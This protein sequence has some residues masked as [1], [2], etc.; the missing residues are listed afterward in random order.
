MTK[1]TYRNWSYKLFPGFYES[2]LYNSDS[3]YYAN[4]F[5]SEDNIRYELKN[6]DG[7]INDVAK[8]ITERVYEPLFIKDDQIIKS[9]KY[10]GLHSPRYYNFETDKILLD[11]EIDQPKLEKY[12]FITNKKD[13]DKYL[14]ENF[15]SYDG[16]N[17]FIENNL[18]NFIIQYEDE[19]KENRCLDLL[20]EFYILS[21]LTEDEIE[22]LQDDMQE[23]ANDVLFEYMERVE[24]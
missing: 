8:K 4:E 19:G 7:F 14:H 1:C 24:E 23:I 15:T 16:F 9:I 18:K 2:N 22:N 12:C 13:F 3:E 17:S 10:N 20:I 6:F 11:L 21:Q 5:L